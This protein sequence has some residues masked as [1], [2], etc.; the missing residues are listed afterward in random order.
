MTTVDVHDLESAMLLLDADRSAEAWVCRSSGVVLIQSDEVGEPV[1]AIPDNVNDSAYFTPIPSARGLDLGQELVFGFVKSD[2]PD[3][4]DAVRQLFR[5]PG[6]YGRYSQ[7][8]DRLGLRER[9][10]RYRD[11]QTRAAL[12]TWCEDHGFNLKE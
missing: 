8:L 12:R 2:M 7:L 1:E 6:A 11:E 4:Y 3:E 10:H 5:R 9:W